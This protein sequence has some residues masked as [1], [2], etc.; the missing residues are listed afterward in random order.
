[1]K[2]REWGGC[3]KQQASFPASAISPD[4]FIC[5]VWLIIIIPRG[6]WISPPVWRGSIILKNPMNCEKSYHKLGQS[7]YDWTCKQKRM[8]EGL[9]SSRPVF[10]RSP[11]LMFLPFEYEMSRSVLCELFIAHHLSIRVSS[12]LIFLNIFSCHIIP[13][14]AFFL[15]LPHIFHPN[16]KPNKLPSCK[17]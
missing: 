3:G 14:C 10:Y 11:F 8:R 16:Q 2:V 17:W 1:M 15:L 9:V 5:A 7:V 6:E 13:E 12:V 4:L